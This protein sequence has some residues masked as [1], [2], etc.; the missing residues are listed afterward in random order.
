MDTLD[1]KIPAI[2]FGAVSLIS[3]LWVMFLP[4][5]NGQPMPE[6]I[7][8]GESFGVGDNCFTS[9]LGRKPNKDEYTV[10]PDQQMVQE[11]DTL[12]Q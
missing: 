2:I 8:D 1:P 3:G 4:E 6:S 10:P 7:E 12:N 9:C 5:T 11:L